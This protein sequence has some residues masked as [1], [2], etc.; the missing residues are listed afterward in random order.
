MVVHALPLKSVMVSLPFWTRKR[1]AMSRVVVPWSCA[2]RWMVSVDGSLRSARAIC[3][4]AAIFSGVRAVVL[5]DL[6]VER[7]ARVA[8]ADVV[9]A[10]VLS[11]VPSGGALVVRLGRFDVGMLVDVRVI[12]AADRRQHEHCN[13]Q[14]DC[15]SGKRSGA[16]DATRP[17][18]M[19]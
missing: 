3:T 15:A 2:S 14:L 10:D 13:Q 17:I 16:G 7:F 18:S 12:R 1:T 5:G 11:D 6:A 19:A 4:A 9:V 8:L